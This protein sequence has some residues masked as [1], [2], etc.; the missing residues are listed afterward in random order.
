MR[1]SPN[2]SVFNHAVKKADPIHKKKASVFDKVNS[3][4]DKDKEFRFS[5]KNHHSHKKGGKE[6]FKAL[7]NVD[8][9]RRLMAS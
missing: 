9:V 8:S 1:F 2:K 7:S 5:H 6:I 3:L 4:A